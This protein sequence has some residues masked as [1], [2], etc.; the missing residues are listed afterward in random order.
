M[1]VVLWKKASACLPDRDV[2]V[3]AGVRDVDGQ[4]YTLILY[5]HDNQWRSC[6]TG[7]IYDDGCV[8]AWTEI[9]I[10]KGDE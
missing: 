9:P 8:E 2:P 6:I 1:Q 4:R 10:W 3:A 7:A 5:R